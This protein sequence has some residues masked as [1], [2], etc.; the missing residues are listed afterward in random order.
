MTVFDIETGDNAA[1]VNRDGV[2][3]I[4][5]TYR[6]IYSQKNG[7]LV[8][9]GGVVNINS[10]ENQGVNVFEISGTENAIYLNG[11]TVNI[12]GSIDLGSSTSGY[13]IYINKG[14]NTV[15][16]GDALV[17]SKWF[18]IG[19]YA[20]STAVPNF[21]IYINP[22]ITNLKL[23]DEKGFM[24]F[25]DNKINLRF[26]SDSY[27]YD[28]SV[29]ED[30][31]QELCRRYGGN[32]NKYDGPIYSNE[33]DSCTA[34][35]INGERQNEVDPSCNPV[36]DN[37]ETNEPSQIVN[38]PATSAYASIVIIVLGIVCVIISIIVTRRV[39]KKS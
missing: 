8:N 1:V 13:G 7:V 26:C 35:Y 27:T 33:L 24:E 38:V 14:F 28:G 30:E 34:V 22:K 31:G 2:L 17:L 32:G 19:Y 4:G 25:I 5:K 9:D 12:N 6:I 21:S 16:G 15:T 11:G 23:K 39:T 10:G 3:N 36:I 20:K 37:D 29:T 18:A